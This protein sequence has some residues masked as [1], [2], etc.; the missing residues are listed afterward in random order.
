MKISNTD[1]SLGTSRNYKLGFEI[2]MVYG[3]EVD[4][5]VIV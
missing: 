5:K 4:N 3:G 1:H 2:P